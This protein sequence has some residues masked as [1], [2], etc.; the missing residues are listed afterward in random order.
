MFFN[1]GRAV[2]GGNVNMTGSPQSSLQDHTERAYNTGALND[3]DIDNDDFLPEAG[4]IQGSDANSIRGSLDFSDEPNDADNSCSKVCPGFISR[5]WNK[6]RN[7]VMRGCGCSKKNCCRYTCL[8][9]G[10]LFFLLLCLYAAMDNF[11]ERMMNDKTWRE[12]LNIND[13]IDFDTGD[14]RWCPDYG[15]G[16]WCP[17]VIKGVEDDKLIIENLNADHDFQETV[18][19]DDRRIATHGQMTATEKLKKKT[20]ELEE[21]TDKLIEELK[22]K[23]IKIAKIRENTESVKKKQEEMQEAV[24]LQIKAVQKQLASELNDLDVKVTKYQTTTEETKQLLEKIEANSVDKEAVQKLVQTK[25]N[26]LWSVKEKALKAEYAELLKKNSQSSSF[27]WDQVV[28]KIGEAVDKEI[29]SDGT[30]EVDYIYEIH[31]CSSIFKSHDMFTSAWMSVLGNYKDCHTALEPI[32]R[33]GDCAPLAGDSGYIEFELL[34][35][36]KVT[37]LRIDHIGQGVST[38]PETTPKEFSLSVAKDSWGDYK[39]VELETNTFQREGKSSQIFHVKN[40]SEQ[41]VKYVRLDILSNYGSEDY[42]CV[43]RIRVHGEPEQKTEL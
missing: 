12:K 9:G 14:G 18:E 8:W 35:P 1:Q 40:V 38:S 29:Y 10:S 20:E 41:F 30:G 23:D 25:V 26:E 21:E 27:S 11:G 2:G 22:Q 42:T 7:G 34:K 19:R 32:R 24:D 36:I 4:S 5:T 3:Q 6:I 31:R 43:Y 37:H 13:K 28:D 39:T 17:A 15:D 16:R 33:A